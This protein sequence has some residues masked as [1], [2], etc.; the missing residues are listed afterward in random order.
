M[1]RLTRCSEGCPSLLRWSSL[2]H[3]L[4]V[5][6]H[7]APLSLYSAAVVSPGDVGWSLLRRCWW[8][9]VFSV[10]A[11]GLLLLLCTSL[12][13]W[14]WISG[15]PVLPPTVCAEFFIFIFLQLKVVLQAKPCKG[16]RCN[17]EGRSRL[18]RISQTQKT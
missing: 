13:R 4:G 9:L 10:G 15:S 6:H 8:G 2:H 5:I 3:N 17:L 14:D 12:R 11:P 7:L 1:S 18:L 16:G